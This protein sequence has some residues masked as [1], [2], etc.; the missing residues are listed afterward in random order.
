MKEINISQLYSSLEYL[1]IRDASDLAKINKYVTSVS[2]SPGE[3]LHSAGEIAN[4]VFFITSGLVRLYYVTA[5]G[6]ELNKSFTREN[7]FVGGAHS[8]QNKEPGRFFVEAME[9]TDCLA[10]PLSGLNTLYLESLAWANLGRQ[11]M[12]AFAS[13]KMLREAE[14]LLDSAEDRYKK[15]LGEQPELANRLP[16]YHIASYLGI[17]DVALSRIRKRIKNPSL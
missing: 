14:F 15:F 3:R 9:P 16:L 12:E 11:F 13:K 8:F 5:D 1:G 2:F 7:Q 10:I 17:T 4:R 6:K